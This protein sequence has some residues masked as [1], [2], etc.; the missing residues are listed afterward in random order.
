MRSQP[1]QDPDLETATIATLPQVVLLAWRLGETTNRGPK[2]K[3]ST[4]AIVAAGIRLVDDEGLEG[5]S[6]AALAKPLGLAATA[7]YRYV[8]SKETLIEL[9]VDSA[10]G[11][12]PAKSPSSEWSENARVWARA[13]LDVYARHPW[14]SDVVITGMPRTPNSLE[15]IESLLESLSD[16][17]LNKSERLSA[18][19]LLQG[20]VRNYAAMIR[21]IPI[22]TD[23]DAS[24]VSL[25]PALG[26]RAYPRLIAEL[27]RPRES[28]SDEF[29]FA[30]DTTIRG[31]AFPHP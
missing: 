14:L 13:L 31:L 28:V 27:Q 16:S 2:P 9:M 26:A 19:L 18:A 3:Q 30:L 4:E 15:W 11:H 12:P 22:G 20:I 8:D 7:L 25:L 17:P 10:V 6:M 24:F 29:D 21:S 1:R 5:L 23:A